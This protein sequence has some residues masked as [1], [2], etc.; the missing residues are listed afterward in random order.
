VFVTHDQHE[1]MEM[2]DRVAVMHA[3]QIVQVDTPGRLSAAP[4]NAFVRSFLGEGR[5]AEPSIA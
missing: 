5:P 3:G 2:A 4:A 1:A